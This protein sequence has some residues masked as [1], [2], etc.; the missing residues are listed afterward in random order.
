MSQRGESQSWFDALGGLE[1]YRSN[2]SSTRSSSVGD[3]H[4]N[5]SGKSNCNRPRT[6]VS[7]NPSRQKSDTRSAS[8]DRANSHSTGTKAPTISNSTRK[9]IESENEARDRI[10]NRARAYEALCKAENVSEEPPTPPSKDE[11]SNSPRLHPASMYPGWTAQGSTSSGAAHE[12]N[13]TVAPSA[14]ANGTSWVPRKPVYTQVIPGKEAEKV[15]NE[16]STIRH[17]K[18]TP[19][20]PAPPVPPKDKPLQLKPKPSGINGVKRR[21]L[22]L[23]LQEAATQSGNSGEASHNSTSSAQPK[24]P[25]PSP[26]SDV[27]PWDKI[28]PYEVNHPRNSQT[29]IPTSVRKSI[30]KAYTPTPSPSTTTFPSQVRRMVTPPRSPSSRTPVSPSYSTTPLLTRSQSPS[31]LPSPRPSTP[32]PRSPSPARG[33]WT[34]DRPRQKRSSFVD[35]AR[36]R[37]KASWHLNMQKAGVRPLSTFEVGLVRKGVVKDVASEWMGGLESPGLEGGRVELDLEVGVDVNVDVGFGV[38]RRRG[39]S[40]DG[41]GRRGEFEGLEGRVRRF[42]LRE[43]QREEGEEE[44]RRGKSGK[45]RARGLSFDAHATGPTR[46]DSLF[47]GAAARPDSETF[48]ASEWSQQRVIDQAREM[49]AQ[50]PASSSFHKGPFGER[51]GDVAWRYRKVG[52]D[53]RR[54]RSLGRGLGTSADDRGR[55][56]SQDHRDSRIPRLVRPTISRRHALS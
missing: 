33:S 49:V 22:P 25:N 38:E 35:R 45:Q 10:I 30:Y 29:T 36:D 41:R 53:S 44:V 21:P 55:L 50:L 2:A 12:D 28:K 19:Y 3:S 1:D 32:I 52:V 7:T 27:M 8:S 23:N 6:A 56:P 4:R 34:C 51:I 54:A 43:S 17:S 9:R 42:Q 48:F 47:L 37:M 11:D 40:E 13:E 31:P 39:R 15:D 16:K 5:K 14:T 26:R 24:T 46:A 20:R 18:Y